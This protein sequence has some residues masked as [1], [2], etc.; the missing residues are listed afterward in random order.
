LSAKSDG[1]LRAQARRLADLPEQN[2]ADVAFSL[3]STRALFEHRAVAVGQRHDSLAAAL[4]RFAGGDL[5][6]TVV[7]GVADLTGKTA[8]VFPG[9]GRSGV[10]MA[11]EL[12]ASSPVFEARMYDCET[13][14]SPYV[15][16]SLTEVLSDAEALERVD[17]VQPVLFATMVSLAALWRSHGVEPD[18]VVGHSQ[19]EIAAACVAGAL[20]LDDAA[21]IV[22]LRSKGDRRFAGRSGRHDV[23]RVAGRQGRALLVDGVFVAATNGPRAAPPANRRPQP[24]RPVVAATKT[25]STSSGS[26][27]VDRQRDRH[28]APRPA[29]EAAIALLRKATIFAAFVEREGAGDA[30]RR[31]LTLRVTDHRVRLDTVRTPTTPPATPSLANNTGCTTSTRSSASASESTSVSDQ[32]T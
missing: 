24:T 31:D 4:D 21:K 30:G 23:G 5:P 12:L 26:T 14:L 3:D 17:V 18:A 29:S 25:P 16:W 8:F 11:T 27:L 13:A 6:A 2:V 19:G 7:H 28:H 15:D 10:D 32:S 20:S 22:A 9:Q 1:S